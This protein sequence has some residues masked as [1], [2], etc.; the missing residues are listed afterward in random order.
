[1]SQK[2]SAETR[3]VQLIGEKPLTIEDILALASGERCA[4]LD[5]SPALARR[6]ELSASILG[7]KLKGGF[8]IYGVST[9]LGDSCVNKLS[10]ELAKS[11]PHNLV[12][13]HGCG[14]GRFLGELE[15]AAVVAVRLAALGRGYSGVRQLLLERLCDILNARVLPCIPEEGSVGAS[16]DLTPLSYL[17]ALLIGEREATFDGEMMESSAALQRAGLEP[18]ELAPKEG[19]ALMN[20]TSVMTAL[21]CLAFHRA[22]KLARLAC[23]I[24]S[25]A[26][27]AMEGEAA[28]FD[29]R[30]FAL[31]P[32]PGQRLAARW[33]AEQLGYDPKTTKHAVR[34]QDRYSIRCAPHV[35][36][37]LVDALP[38]V[39]RFLETELNGVNDNP[40]IDPE[41]GDVLHSGNF[42][43]GHTCFAMDGL[44]AAVANLAD[45]ADRQL[46]LLCNESFNNGLPAN[47]LGMTGPAAHAHH[48]FKAMQISAS[49]LAAEALKLTMPA[50]VFSRSTECHN[51]DKVSMGT[52]AARDALRI[53]ELTERGLAITLLGACQALDLRG[54]IGSSGGCSEGNRRIYDAVRAIVPMTIEDRRHDLDIERIVDALDMDALGLGSLEEIDAMG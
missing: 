18:L 10:P 46:A 30:I 26:S 29:D 34:V 47:L 13:Y 43:G 9:G 33:I 6:I 51:Q 50:S 52:I 44:K 20:G 21:G 16:G 48:G 3:P 12:R 35:I 28:H 14:T 1:M 40:I 41:T 32:H 2:N 19:L 22:R 4:A 5:P 54:A 38:L 15:S 24:T 8:T 49:A 36:G 17:A 25:L 31:K 45:L 23:A 7:E 37:V 53:I 42:Y 11:L 39:R 27:A